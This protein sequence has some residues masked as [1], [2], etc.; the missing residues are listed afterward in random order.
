ML[1]M[2]D[3]EKTLSST[4]KEALTVGFAVNHFRS[5]LLVKKFTLITDHSVLCWLYSIEA[6][7]CLGRW[8]MDLQEYEFNVEE[9]KT[10]NRLQ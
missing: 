7:A 5:Y 8:V 10:V 2:K 1:S 6:K 9:C 3:R 4:E